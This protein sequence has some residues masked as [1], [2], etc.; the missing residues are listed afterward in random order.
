MVQFVK[1][2]W[3]FVGLSSD[4]RSG[5][6]VRVE[7][8]GEPITL[9]RRKDGQ[10]FALRDIC[11]HRAAPLSAGRIVDDTVECPYHGWRFYGN[12]TCAAIP[13][14]HPDDKTDVSKI[15]VRQ[16][17]VREEGPL[18]WVYLSDKKTA[19]PDIDPPQIEKAKGKVF[20]D[21]QLIMNADIDQAALGLIDPAHG[22]Y[23]HQQWWWRSEHKMKIKEKLFEP[24]QLG[25]AMAAHKP[26]SNSA[27]YKLLGGERQTEITFYLPG[28]RTED[29]RVGDKHLLSLTAMTP[30]SETQTQFRQIFF[31]NMLSMRFMGPAFR[32]GVRRF[33]KQ[34]S[35][36]LQLQ[37]KNLKYTP[38][39]MFVGDADAQARW[40]YAFKKEWAASREEGRDFQHPVK[41]QTLRYRT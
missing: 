10:L 9:G 23:V 15:S 5:Q 12:G 1:D 20:V 24:R 11:P 3:Y 8:A 19:K 38:K 18:I 14:L 17:P 35:G 13:A 31:T 21:E 2:I 7:I 39:Q 29:I 26:S 27:A 37:G 40:Y 30:V 32:V 41:K 25:F 36:I 16:Y 28:I 34:D 22:P 6:M 33:L 4:V